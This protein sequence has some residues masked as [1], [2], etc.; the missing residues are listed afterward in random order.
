MVDDASTKKLWSPRKVRM[1]GLSKKRLVLVVS[2][3]VVI[4]DLTEGNADV[5]ERRRLG[6]LSVSGISGTRQSLNQTTSQRMTCS[7]TYS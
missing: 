4:L 6:Q 3:L 7:F 5:G 2:I 1:M